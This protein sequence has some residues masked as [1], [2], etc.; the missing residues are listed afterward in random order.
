MAAHSYWMTWSF[1]RAIYFGMR[2]L[3]LA[4]LP[5]A[6]TRDEDGLH[7]RYWLLQCL[8]PT[9]SGLRVTLQSSASAQLRLIEGLLSPLT[10]CATTQELPVI[11]TTRRFE[12]LLAL[13]GD[14]AFD[15]ATHAYRL[16][17]SAIDE[18]DPAVEAMVELARS[19]WMMSGPPH[20]VFG[21]GLGNGLWQRAWHASQG[22]GT[23]PP[24]PA[25]AGG[26]GELLR[27]WSLLAA[28]RRPTAP[29]GTMPLAWAFATALRFPRVD[30]DAAGLTAHLP[31]PH[32]LE[33][34]RALGH[35]VGRRIADAVIDAI[36]VV[37][38]RPELETLVGQEEW[39]CLLA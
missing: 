12:S 8:S 27:Y 19:C 24:T 3:A 36:D 5:E 34:R 17:E 10:A 35:R 29:L 33:I 4:C 26:F 38:A 18:E 28:S 11:R 32:R 14:R 30:W 13:L 2:G 1:E 7:F 9:V 22:R 20:S 37:D 39:R 15:E 6:R 16:I 25:F 23:F 31:R 21:L